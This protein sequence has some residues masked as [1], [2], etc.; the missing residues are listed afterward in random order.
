[1]AGIRKDASGMTRFD[2]QA[3]LI[4]LLKDAGEEGL[5]KK[6]ILQ[7]WSSKELL[8]ADANALIEKGVMRKEGDTRGVTYFYVDRTKTLDRS[9]RN[10][11]RNRNSEG[12]SDPTASAA[13]REVDK[14]ML[15]LK[16][17]SI[18]EHR[19]SN[20]DTYDFLVMN[21]YGDNVTGFRLC[22]A[23]AGS[24]SHPYSM[25]IGSIFKNYFIDLSRISTV[26]A[27]FLSHSNEKLATNFDEIKDGLSD[28]LGIIGKT[29]EVE[30]VV[31]K[32]VEKE[33]PVEVDTSE[34]KRELETRIALLEAKIEVYKEAFAA[35]GCGNKGVNIYG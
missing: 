21:S 15:D 34:E 14:S 32:V 8:Q 9:D 7:I 13:I 19:T 5:K 29:V 12:Y 17:G 6:D 33:V 24:S 11:E 16:P 30:K 1:M 35:F 31:E 27:K 25:R 3:T 23:W 10:L 18:V 26:P 28:Y 22:E 4:S 2:R 20:G